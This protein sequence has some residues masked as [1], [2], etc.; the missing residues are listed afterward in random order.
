MKTHISLDTV[1]LD[2]SVSF[3][4]TLLNAAP[5]KIK[6]DYALF[7][8][9]EPELELA[10]NLRETVQPA[11]DAHYG[12]Y[13]ET[14]DLVDDATERLTTAGFADSVE[15]EETCCYAKQTK[16]W[17][18]DPDGRRWEVYSVLEDTNDRDGADSTCCSAENAEEPCCA[19][20]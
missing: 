14:A 4:S 10:L 16:V 11:N 19:S 2:R 12:I 8:T 20:A 9:G 5:A 15:R 17:A 6:P 18:T 7:V 13:V 1:D 3:Y